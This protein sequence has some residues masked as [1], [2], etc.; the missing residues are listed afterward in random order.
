MSFHYPRRVKDLPALEPDS[1]EEDVNQDRPKNGDELQKSG[2]KNHLAVIEAPPKVFGAFSN[3]RMFPKRSSELPTLDSDESEEEENPKTDNLNCAILNDSFIM[4]P[5]DNS[6]LK[7][8][9]PPSGVKK[10]RAVGNLSFLTDFNKLALNTEGKE[11]VNKT[12]DLLTAVVENIQPNAAST[13]RKPHVSRAVTSCPL[14]SIQ[15]DKV[16][17]DNLTGDIGRKSNENCAGAVLQRFN[18][19]P[20][21]QKNDKYS[22]LE[23]PLRQNNNTALI[24]AVAP[25]NDGIADSQFATPQIRSFSVQ[26][27]PRG[28]CSTQSQKER[29]AIANEF[30]SQK[31][32]FQTPMAITRA[33]VV[34]LPNDS[35]TLSLCDSINGAETTPKTTEKIQQNT[36]KNDVVKQEVIVKSKKS[37]ENAFSKS[38][39]LEEP[40]GKNPPNTKSSESK[41]K[42]GNL[43]INNSDYTIIKKI[44]CGGS[45][46]VYLAKRNSDGTECA[47]KV[48]DLRGDPVVVEGYLNET[49]LL[50]KLQGNICVVAL[51]EYQLLR[52]ES[53]LFLVMEK[54]DSDLH[55]I[56]QT[57]TTNLPLYVL[58]NFWYQILQAVNYIHQ[59]GVIHSD[60]KPANFLMIN[61]RLKL[62]DFGIASNIALDSTSIIKFSQAG[63]FNYISPEALTDT[64][65]GS[66]PMRSNQPK[67]KISTKSDV[68]SLGCIL[69]LLLYK[70]TPFSHIKNIYAKI[71]AITS[72]TTNIEYP[73]IPLYYP[74]MLV[75]MAK[76]CLQHNPKKRPSCAELLQYPFNMVIPI[77]NLAVPTTIKE[78]N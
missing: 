14:Q 25:T 30:R 55:K 65:T 32:L 60:L 72:P 39:K 34:C 57:Y 76:N 56:L 78:K 5:A 46:S 40:D 41:E 61:G 11:N 70:R 1:D 49:K 63:T 12:E 75:H 68:W 64:S 18:S 44:G 42:E 27:R 69:Y 16:A 48:V 37:L 26:R 59:N 24:P 15:E 19:D 29:T 73:T 28:L 77:Q 52:N 58:M 8:P 6:V 33:P 31:V 10:K 74:A 53:R 50:A 21:P 22:D 67:I 54:G 47:L 36:E 7:T 4:S 35:I 17:N 51:Y 9:G 20:T 3:M 38:D 43:H 45:S 71:N 13:A 2:S 62:I 66:S 23:T